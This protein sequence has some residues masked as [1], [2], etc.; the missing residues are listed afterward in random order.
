MSLKTFLSL[1]RDNK[2]NKKDN[3]EDNKKVSLAGCI[4]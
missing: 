4:I 3:K 2:D 1:K